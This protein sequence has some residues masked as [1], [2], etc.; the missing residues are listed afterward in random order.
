MEKVCLIT[1]FFVNKKSVITLWLVL[2]NFQNK[3]LFNSVITSENY[4]GQHVF[5]LMLLPHDDYF[6]NKTN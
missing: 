5:I 1:I 6:F 3:N 4:F 2:Q